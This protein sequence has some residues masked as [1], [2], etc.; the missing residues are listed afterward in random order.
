MMMSTIDVGGPVSAFSKTGVE[1]Q[2]AAL[3]GVRNADFNYVTG[4]ATVPC[5]EARTSL[6]A[7]QGRWG[8]RTSDAQFRDRSLHDVEPIAW[9]VVYRVHVVEPERFGL[10]PGAAVGQAPGRADWQIGAI[11]RAEI[12]ETFAAIM[13]AIVK[14][15][16]LAEGAVN[17]DGFAIVHSHPIGETGPILT[18]PLLDA[19]RRCQRRR[20]L[21]TLCI[22]G[23]QD[24]ALGLE[25]IH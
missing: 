25:S 19:L 21:V 24:A 12:N 1:R 2:L 18:T 9:F 14:E 23:S 6:Q 17:V 5:D 13:P 20:A 16:G 22:G 3:P 11:E 10:T 4:S 15:L 8:Y 7:I